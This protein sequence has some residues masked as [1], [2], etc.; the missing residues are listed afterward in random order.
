MIE[1]IKAI[2]LNN[3]VPIHKKMLADINGE[4]LNRTSKKS[5]S[6][7]HLSFLIDYK[8]REILCFSF[9]L[10]YKS[11]KFPFS[12]HS[13]I[14]TITKFY[15]NNHRL[16]KNKFKSKKILIVLK[17]TKRGKLGNSKPC[18][19]CAN[20][21]NNNLH[22]LNLIHIYYS[23]QYNTLD[24]LDCN[25]LKDDKFRYSSGSMFYLKKKNDQKLL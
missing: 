24:K 6:S 4:L 11:D 16:E 5:K 18:Q 22:N 23:T 3:N 1:N 10:Y 2:L 13:E 14:N 25:E 20:Y 19:T 21:I 7:N 15:K 8:S 17:L 9:N 12:I